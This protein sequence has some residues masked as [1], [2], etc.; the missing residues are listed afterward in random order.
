M[1]NGP[2]GDRDLPHLKG[3]KFLRLLR[4]RPG[5]LVCEILLD[6]RT[7]YLK[8]FYGDDRATKVR[9]IAERLSS[10]AATL[11]QGRDAVALPLR[12][13]PDEGYLVFD[14]APGQPVAEAL[15]A[16]DR[17]ERDRLIA[18]VGIW[19]LRLV[20]QSL[21]R[22]PFSATYWLRL[23]ERRLAVAGRHIPRHALLVAFVEQLRIES[24][25]LHGVG[26]ER[27]ASHGDLTPD[28][29]FWDAARDRMTGIDLAAR[30]EIPVALD[31][32]RLLVWL[33][34][35]RTQPG[36]E[37][38]DGID[39]AD[40]AALLSVPGLLADDQ[41]PVLRYLIGVMML[42]YYTAASHNAA[43]R[44]ILAR[45]MEDWIRQAP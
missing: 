42:A 9:A 27:G 14:A 10:A 38:T 1:P 44:T 16:A 26:V 28:N 7:A 41:R 30:S 21:E 2:E 35:R 32:A 40:H 15:I 31:A 17:A 20:A 29:L 11:G 34:S 12:I 39:T 6:G 4:D 24:L 3:G 19:L 8:Q 18:R 33:E 23:S 22:K 13:A 36:S 43:R 25:H 37:V 5:H 45:A